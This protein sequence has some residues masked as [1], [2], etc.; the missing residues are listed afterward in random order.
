MSL[1]VSTANKLVQQLSSTYTSGNRN[2][3]PVCEV[4]ERGRPFDADAFS[5]LSN[6]QLP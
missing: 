1:S 6:Y 2:E 4:R 3:R 5:A